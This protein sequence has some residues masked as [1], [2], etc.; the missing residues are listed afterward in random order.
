MATGGAVAT[1]IAQ[2]AAISNF[3]LGSTLGSFYYSIFPA[4]ASIGL[5]IASIGSVMVALA[6]V[7][8]FTGIL[9]NPIQA[10]LRL[11]QK[12]LQ[13]FIDC[14][15]TELKGTG[16]AKFEIKDRY[17]ACVFDIMDMLKTAAETVV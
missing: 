17:V 2:K 4:S 15:E 5:I 7:T 3:L 8:S 13:R 10:K 16:E 11:H 12:R 1:T 6:I 14:I 9:T